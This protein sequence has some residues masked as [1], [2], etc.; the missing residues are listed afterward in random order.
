MN[1]LSPWKQLAFL[2]PPKYASTHLFLRLFQGWP[3]CPGGQGSGVPCAA[4]VQCVLSSAGNVEMFRKQA[5][6]SLRRASDWFL[7]MS[8][9]YLSIS[10]SSSVRA[11]ACVCMMV[12]NT[13][14]FMWLINQCICVFDCP[15]RTS[16]P[17]P[18]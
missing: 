18:T 9:P 11:C 17:R 15:G 7:G 4:N 2:V 5:S 12:V 10:A 13:S 16:R 1:N 3:S 14:E 8:L 6:D